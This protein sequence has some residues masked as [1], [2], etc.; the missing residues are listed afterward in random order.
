MVPKTHPLPSPATDTHNDEKAGGGTFFSSTKESNH[1]ILWIY[2]LLDET[3][4][5]TRHNNIF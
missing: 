5:T 2:L 1:T 4:Y 3:K